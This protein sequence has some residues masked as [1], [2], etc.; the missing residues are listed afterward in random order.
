MLRNEQSRNPCHLLVAGCMGEVLAG[1]GGLC[2]RL[3][4]LAVEAR[5]NGTKLGARDSCLRPHRVLT[6]LCRAEEHTSDACLQHSTLQHRT[7]LARLTSL[8]CSV[9]K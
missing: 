8:L 1:G 4:T 7:T 2:V 5:G 6:A 3:K 9:H